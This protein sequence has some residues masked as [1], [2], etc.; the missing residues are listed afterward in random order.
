[1][2]PSRT[3]APNLLD[4]ESWRSAIRTSTRTLAQPV[5]TQAPPAAVATTTQLCM[6]ARHN[7]SLPDHAHRNPNETRNARAT[8]GR[9]YWGSLNPNSLDRTLCI[10]ALFWPKQSITFASS[11]DLSGM[12]RAWLRLSPG[13]RVY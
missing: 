8:T 5:R 12:D 11:R 3:P 10:I 2:K 6:R 13:F 1:M 7:F 9:R 4:T